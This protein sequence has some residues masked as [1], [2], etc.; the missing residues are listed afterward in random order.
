MNDS[1]T[2]HSLND[3]LGR[4]VFVQ[5]ATWFYV[6]RLEGFGHE[7]LCLV[8]ASCIT[9]TGTQF[10]EFLNEGPRPEGVIK[11]GAVYPGTVAEPFPDP[12]LIM[13]GGVISVTLWR[14]PVPVVTPDP[15]PL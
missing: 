10:N 15:V 11:S 7:E 1:N 14:H 5:T 4:N 8:D 2:I 6:G 13:R 9:C 12:I 3:M